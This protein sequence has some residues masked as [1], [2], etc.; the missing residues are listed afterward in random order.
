V[1]KYLV[2]VIR[3][4]SWIVGVHEDIIQVYHDVNIQEIRKEGVKE[5]L[6]SSW[7]IGK[8][9][10]NDPKIIGAITGAES[11][12]VLVAS[13]DAEQVIGVA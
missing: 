5:P 9:F 10:R 4:I 2:N 7:C 12:F 13:G 8:T 11:G 3:M 6:E 1:A